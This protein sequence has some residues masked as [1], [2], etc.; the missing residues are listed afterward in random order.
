M[1]C[2]RNIFSLLTGDVNKDFLYSLPSFLGSNFITNL[3]NINVLTD[4]HTWCVRG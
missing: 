4:I 2:Y 3:I 1:F